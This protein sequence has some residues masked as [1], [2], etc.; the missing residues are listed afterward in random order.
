MIAR[1]LAWAKEASL[2]PNNK[3]SSSR[4]SGLLSVTVLQGVFVSSSVSLIKAGHTASFVELF[5][6]NAILTATLLG[7]TQVSKF[8]K[9][10]PEG[11]T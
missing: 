2:G 11:E 9:A 8:A 5:Q 1:F 6:A 3:V 10:K 7:I 4:V